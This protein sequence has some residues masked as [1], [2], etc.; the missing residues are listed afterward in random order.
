M[1]FANLELWNFSNLSENL[2]TNDISNLTN[3][4]KLF[5]DLIVLKKLQLSLTSTKERRKTE[6]GGP[7]G[8]RHKKG[9]ENREETSRCLCVHVGCMRVSVQSSVASAE[10]TTNATPYDA[11]AWRSTCM[12]HSPQ[13]RVGVRVH[14]RIKTRDLDMLGGDFT[15]AGCVEERNLRAFAESQVAWM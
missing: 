7:R 12:A 1:N 9:A 15:V 10:N 13:H 8:E 5:V 3:M 6:N 2:R 11:G 14:S 4:L